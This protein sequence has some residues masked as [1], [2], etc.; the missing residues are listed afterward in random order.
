MRST[1]KPLILAGTAIAVALA[2]TPMAAHAASGPASVSF[3]GTI[4]STMSVNDGTNTGSV[5]AG[6]PYTGTF[7]YDSAQV[8]TP[9]AYGGGTK[10]TY[11]F[12][13]LTFTIGTSTATSGPGRIDVYDNLTSAQGYPNGDSVYVNFAGVAPS[14]LLAGAEF[15]WMGVALL[16]SSGAAITGGALP[17]TLSI[18]SFPTHFTEF[19]FGTLGTPWGAGNTSM[20]QSLTS[21]ATDGTTPPPPPPAAISFAPGL[22]GGTVGA[23]YS[24]TFADAA[25]GTGAFTYSATGLPPGLALSGTTVSG[26]PTVAGTYPVTLTATDSSGA[27][28]S[29]SLSVDIAPAPACTGTNAVETAYVAR[30]PGY[31]VVNGGLNLLDHLWTSNLNAGNTTFLGGLTNWYQTGLI[32]SWT[33]TVDP[34]GCI[35]DHL[36][37]APPVAVSTTSLPPATAG[38]AYQAAVQAG[39]G[40]APYKLSVTGLPAGL[41][42]DGSNITGTPTSAGSYPLTM[43]ATDSV[44]ATASAAVTLTVAP[45]GSYTVVDEGKGKITA[46][47]P[48]RSYLMVGNKKLIW[49]SSTF[50]IVNTP[51]GERHVIDSF[52]ITGMRVQWKGLRD[53]ATNTVLTRQLEVN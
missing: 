6:T 10:T 2:G 45:G 46:I 28:A 26:T 30:N 20:I 16:D 25:G 5:P 14:G 33:G 21:L 36:T 40:V 13:T 3:A 37:V 1:F 35:L 9:V 12:T 19:N 27:A 39:W 8:P 49:D 15:N 4:S 18:A 43:T 38:V 52:V 11:A 29:A 41:S 42:F 22:P 23:W 31:I 44:N 24:T 17:A 51:S 47:A 50:I 32:V 48:D 7:S 34:N 53:K